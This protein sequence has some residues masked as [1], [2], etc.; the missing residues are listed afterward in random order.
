[1]L[2]IYVNI[3]ANFAVLNATINSVLPAYVTGSLSPFVDFRTISYG[4]IVH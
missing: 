1:M 3:S 2:R 4:D